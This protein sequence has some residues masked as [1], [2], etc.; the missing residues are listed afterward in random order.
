MTAGDDLATAPG[1]IASQLAASLRRRHPR[2]HR[3]RGVAA[4]RSAEGGG[5][6]GWHWADGGWWAMGLGMVTWVVLLAITVALIVRLVNRNAPRRKP[7]SDSA[8]E[9]LRRRYA[10]GEM[11]TEEHERR[12]SVLRR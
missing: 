7:G 2:H 12:L 11:D 3:G 10:S 6:M 5:K 4:A 9:V 8:E 1:S